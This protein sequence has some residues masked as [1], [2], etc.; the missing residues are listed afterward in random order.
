MDSPRFPMLHE[1]QHELVQH[2]LLSLDTRSRL[3]VL[4]T[5]R[6]AGDAVLAAKATLL[7]QCYPPQGAGLFAE[8]FANGLAPA[9]IEKNFLV[10]S[11]R[12]ELYLEAGRGHI[13]K[14]SLRDVWIAGGGAASLSFGRRVGAEIALASDGTKWLGRNHVCGVRLDRV[15]ICGTTTLVGC[16]V[17]NGIKITAGATLELVGCTV[18]THYP[19]ALRV[20]KGA[21]L[22][23]TD[24]CFRIPSADEL[25]DARAQFTDGGRWHDQRVVGASR[26]GGSPL[27]H[28]RAEHSKSVTLRDCTLGAIRLGV[29]LSLE[30]GENL[31]ELVVEGCHF[32]GYDDRTSAINLLRGVLPDRCSIRRN[33]L[34]GHRGVFVNNHPG[35]VL[36]LEDNHFA[37]GSIAVEAVNGVHVR[38]VG[39]SVQPSEGVS[40]SPAARCCASKGSSYE[41]VDV[42]LDE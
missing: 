17:I 2:I 8:G 35:A 29:C 16:L 30:L 3:A 9:R 34:A 37:N 36:V 24:C 40:G 19:H 32:G 23:A 18:F 26:G 22:V 10:R 38:V 11:K 13:A 20:G 5:C 4:L 1:L 33:R 25:R 27:Y 6:N 15:E 31:E 28:V 42:P 7:A 39:S 14:G 41:I 12:R 21:T